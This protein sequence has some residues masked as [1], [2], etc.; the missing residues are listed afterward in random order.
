M[1]TNRSLYF[2]QLLTPTMLLCSG[3]FPDVQD[4]ISQ[5]NLSQIYLTQP[6]FSQTYF[7]PNLLFPKPSFTQTYSFPNQLL[8]KP[9]FSQTI[10]YTNL[11]FPKP[12]FTQ[13]IHKFL[14]LTQLQRSAHFTTLA[15]LVKIKMICNFL[16]LQ[17]FK[18]ST[19]K[20]QT[21]IL[22]LPNTTLTIIFEVGE[23]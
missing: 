22:G 5:T 17:K 8:H 19:K 20:T 3:N 10:F 7:F 11:L 1:Y 2:L 14:F 4:L 9:T 21:V 13:N 6:K 15:N 18:F 23:K 12:T 16:R